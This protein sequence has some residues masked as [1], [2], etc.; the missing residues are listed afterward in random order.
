MARALLEVAPQQAPNV[1][2]HARVARRV[3]AMTPVIAVNAR[4]LEAARIAPETVALL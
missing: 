4:E 2:E 3:Q 1:V